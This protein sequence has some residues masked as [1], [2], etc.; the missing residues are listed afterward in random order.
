[1]IRVGSVTF[2]PAGGAG[3]VAGIL[4]EQLQSFGDL[5]LTAIMGMSNQLPRPQN[6][7][8][9][10][11][12]AI[13]RLLVQNRKSRAQGIF[14][15]FRNGSKI[16]KMSELA[17]FDVLHL[18]WPLGV[19]SAGDIE[20]LSE[21]ETTQIVITLHDMYFLTG[22]CHHS[23]SCEGF[24]HACEVCPMTRSIV[25]D[26][27]HRAKLERRELLSKT[28]VH[29]VAPSEWMRNRARLA[30]PDKRIHLIPNPLGKIGKE[31]SEL[32]KV[33]KLSTEKV[34]VFVTSY[35]Q[36]QYKRIDR[37]I[38]L[39]RI[40]REKGG[41]D[42]VLKV[43]FSRGKPTAFAPNIQYI[44]V[45]DRD[46]V[47]RELADANFN[48]STSSAETFSMTSAEAAF[49]QTPTIALR[50]TAI[51]DFVER[52]FAKT[53]EDVSEIAEFLLQDG[54]DR[55]AN[56]ENFMLDGF[57]EGEAA[58]NYANLYREITGGLSE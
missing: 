38:E 22:G 33:R 15:A 37:A 34:L 46:S 53:F 8:F 25:R 45:S 12:T 17:G 26:R 5:E 56:P 19:I 55:F 54:S 47:I 36:D 41:D 7:D 48:L 21:Q 35:L 32:K 11:L 16:Y 40:I 28:N 42:W 39:M 30:F 13:D 43:V 10:F 18:H 9:I 52:K 4:Q 2:S 29:L 1:M 49:V 6:A 23:L 58:K 14:S 20:K 57:S 31:S 3:V 44:K 24:E 27:V 50:G 51:D